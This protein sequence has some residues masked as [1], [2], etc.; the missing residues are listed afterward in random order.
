MA[1]S[2]GGKKIISGSTG[3]GPLAHCEF[4]YKLGIGVC[5]KHQSARLESSQG[6][7]DVLAHPPV[8]PVFKKGP[9]LVWQVRNKHQDILHH[10]GTQ[11]E[12]HAWAVDT[13]RTNKQLGRLF[14]QR[15]GIA[16]GV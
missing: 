6:P 7:S 13:L 9:D 14:L 3:S 12:A 15:V 2:R 11:A 16:I 1:R 8:F 5:P 4:C 10:A